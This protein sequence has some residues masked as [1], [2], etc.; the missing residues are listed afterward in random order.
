MDTAIALL[1]N[2]LKSA[3]AIQLVRNRFSII[4]VHFGEKKEEIIDLAHI[5]GI[6][7]I[8]FISFEDYKDV[9]LNKLAMMKMAEFVADKEN[10]KTI[11][12]GEHIPLIASNHLEATKIINAQ[13]NKT[14]VRP[15]FSLTE[16]EVLR[17]A[18]ENELPS[19]KISPSLDLVNQNT[20]NAISK[21]R[22]IIPILRENLKNSQ[23]IEVS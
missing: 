15:V 3:V 17:I 6:R 8:Y 22:Q 1:E 21:I 18:N 11:I 2:D 23:V 16:E 10:A 9:L 12:T 4:A 19:M 14:V 7:Y 5:L 20:E 13:L